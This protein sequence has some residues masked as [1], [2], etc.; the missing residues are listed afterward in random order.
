[1]RFAF[2]GTPRLAA[3]ILDGLLEAGLRPELVVTRADSV[4]RRG[5]S[6]RPSAVAVRAGEAGLPVIKPETLKQ[7]GLS[8]QLEALDLDLV[9]LVAYGKIISPELLALPRAGWIN[10]HA[11]LLPR[12]RGA[13]PLQRAVLAGDA[14]TGVSIMRM[15][16]GLDTGP[17]C[18]QASVAIGD[19]YYEELE[20]ALIA[21]GTDLLVDELPKICAGTVCWQPQD[22]TSVTYADKIGKGE[23]D[24][25]LEAKP[26]LNLR[27]VRASSDSA[28]A[29]FRLLAE[30]SNGVGEELVLR[31]LS[32]ELIDC[33][34][35]LSPALPQSQPVRPVAG[36]IFE[37]YSDLRPGTVLASKDTLALV[38]TEPQR[39]C[40]ITCLQR[41]GKRAL[42]AADFLRG[43]H[44]T[45]Y[46]QW[47]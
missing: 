35:L 21:A 31:A 12:W 37:S 45:E 38:S 11:S 40:A 16:A 3:G 46:L 33:V 32:A 5:S 23:L 7:P 10:A 28:P 26:E 39:C 15:A 36:A 20:D 19:K 6:R 41:P 24:L 27:R 42:P 25:S 30:S 18:A 9:I 13:A 17:Y 1:M 44:A 8:A 14:Q 22:E 2:F 43:L 29:R 34:E 4:S 47:R